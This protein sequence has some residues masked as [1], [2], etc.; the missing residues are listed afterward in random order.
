ML[1]FGERRKTREKELADNSKSRICEHLAQCF[2]DA[3]SLR[4]TVLPAT[5]AEWRLA[6]L[7]ALP[8]AP[9]LSNGAAQT[10]IQAC[11]TPGHT[12]PQVRGLQSQEKHLE[13]RLQAWKDLLVAKCDAGA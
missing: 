12:H 1:R 9:Q 10:A 5:G 8:R 2:T 6:G 7:T 13:T 3:I 11:L 4:F